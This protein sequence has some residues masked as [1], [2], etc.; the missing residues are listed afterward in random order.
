MMR[1]EGPLIGRESELAEL[2]RMLTCKRLVTVTGTGGC[3]KT[4]LALELADR[5]GSQDATAES[6]RPECV[7]VPLAS[8]RDKERLID[9]LLAALGARERFGS[10]PEQILLDCVA[11]RRMLLVLDNCEHLVAAVAGMAG[12]LLDAAPQLRVL[13]TSREPLAAD[14]ESV[15]RLGPL[16][17]PEADGGLGALVRSEAG[18]LFIDRAS[19]VNPGFTLAPSSA[20]AVAR[21]CRGLDGLP[22]A[23][24]L[25]AARLDTLSAEEI[26][27]GLSRRGRLSAGTRALPPEPAVG[28]EELSQHR[29]VRASLDWSYQLLDESEQAMMRRLSAFSGGFTAAAAHAVAA[30]ETTASRVRSLLDELEAKGL[31]ARVPATGQNRWTLLQIVGEYAA[32]QLASEGE[33]E[34]VADRHLA[35]FRA[36]AAR[37]NGLLAEAD[38][39]ER[40]DE[41]RSNLRL[42][43]DRGI[44]H[45][46]PG[47]LELAASLM[48]HWMLA[49][50]YQEARTVCAAVRSAAG[51]DADIGA[52]ALVRCG[53]GLVDMLSEDYTAAIESTKAGLELLGDV[54]DIRVQA[55]CLLFSSMVL[56]QTGLDLGEGLRNAQRAVELQQAAEDPLGLAFT[57]VNLAIAAGLCDRFDQVRGAYEEFLTI[58]NA[59]EHSR[60]RTWAEHAVAWA[61]IAVGSPT[62]ALEHADHA[63]ALE[64]EWPSMTHFQIVGFRIHALARQGRTDQALEEGGR[65]IQRAHE[66]GAL[67]AVPAIELAL[68][69]AE[70]AHGDLDAADARARE[71]LRMPHLHTLALARE[72]L[73]RIALAR[74]DASEAEAQARE[75]ETIAERSGSPR[76]RALADLIA[77]SAAIQAGEPEPGR[78][79][80][81]AALTTQVELDLERDVADVLDE[82]ALLAAGTEDA[83]RA[84]RLAAA[85]NSTRARLGCA[86]PPG[87][88]DRL[89]QVR[90]RLIEDGNAACWE[91]AWAQGQQL[92]LSDAIAYARRG[93]GRRDRPPAGWASLTPTE[94]DIAQL[95]ANGLSNPQIATQLFIARST[96]KMHLSNVYRKLHVANRVA[97]TAAMA[98]RTEDPKPP[99]DL[100]AAGYARQRDR[101]RFVRFAA[102]SRNRP[103]H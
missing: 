33:R 62:R 101:V 88:T 60:L 56:I 43:L 40:I 15:F 19:R 85:A 61:E 93:R 99:I 72:T 30:P 46:P 31:I 89:D 6:K 24:V 7:V 77:G 47:A 65:A 12:K 11:P 100:Q 84:A 52:S 36:Y 75:L 91:Q 18:R 57:L 67:Q 23:L 96:V 38:G 83:P 69:I 64:G 49:E 66:S 98:T 28:E 13:A 35:W 92:L 58:P 9:A 4:R 3:G 71:L 81:H 59:C 34:Q 54:Q 80:L 21:I 103:R 41:E 17:L 45:D 82:L 1:T 102:V 2:E 44:E 86:P 76:H 74:G 63:L 14:G 87:T 51:G 37:A 16:S 39:H 68:M 48:R 8:M 25:A 90:A 53:A 20:R 22:L 5:V 55:D 78:D 50:R 29:S 27:R 97:L 42:A 94:L 79:R 70:F 10:T 95:A 73:A 26:A 32:E